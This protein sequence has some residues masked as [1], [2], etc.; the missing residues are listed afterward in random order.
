M[1]SRPGGTGT[2]IFEADSS[3]AV[4][5]RP[6][7]GGGRNVLPESHPIDV[8][9]TETARRQKLRPRADEQL[10]RA[11]AF[12][13]CARLRG[14]LGKYAEHESLPVTGLSEDA[15]GGPRGIYVIEPCQERSLV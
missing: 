14:E 3:A 9:A 6:S 12:S 11:R 1:F 7:G 8:M 15:R 10:V 4:P 2:L 5:R 13:A